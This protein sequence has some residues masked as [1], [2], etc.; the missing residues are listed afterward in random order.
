MTAP[1]IGL[2][3]A[4]RVMRLETDEA[5]RSRTLRLL[6][7]EWRK[8]SPAEGAGLAGDSDREREKETNGAVS[9]APLGEQSK[10]SLNDETPNEAWL[11]KISKPVVGSPPDWYR[12]I[13]ALP[14]DTVA[15]E[16][17]RP[18]VE[19]LLAPGQQRLILLALVSKLIE[20][21]DIDIAKTARSIVSRRALI[22]LPRQ[23]RLSV[24]RGVQLI[25]DVGPRMQPFVDDEDQLMTSLLRILGR[26]VV[27]ILR[28]YGAPPDDPESELRY[29][30][31]HMPAPGTPV[32]LL[33]EVGEG[34]GI[35]APLTAKSEQWIGFAGR[36]ATYGCQLIVLAPVSA[37]HI[38]STL[39]QRTV[40]VPWDRTPIG[41]TLLTRLRQPGFGKR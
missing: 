8:S 13:P 34:K 23:R 6:G 3:D 27:E 5:A 40:V 25:I 24:R 15:P 37:E 35:F 4:L 18:K 10:K 29:G 17:Q 21:R 36:L 30:E 26:D 41:Q 31:Y 28:C 19:P 12:R 32:L 39:R 20:G 22:R 7:F 38:S 33:S 11:H 14:P 1:Q 2:A 9:A 16:L